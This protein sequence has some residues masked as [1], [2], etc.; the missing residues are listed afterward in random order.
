MEPRAAAAQFIPAR[1]QAICAAGRVTRERQQELQGAKWISN[2]A[3][4]IVRYINELQHY[5]LSN[6]T[7]VPAHT[8]H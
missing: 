3:L 2:M 1:R 5:T 4:F 8:K 6:I 7:S